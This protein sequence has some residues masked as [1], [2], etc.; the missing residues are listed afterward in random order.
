MGNLGRGGGV[1]DGAFAGFVG[2]Q[3]ALDAVHDDGA[4]SAGNGG[5]RRE[6]I[7]EDEPEDGRNL[8]QV[9]DQDDGRN[10]Q[11]ETGH[12]RDQPFRDFRDDL[13]AT[14]DNDGDEDRD[15]AAYDGAVPAQGSFQGQGDGVGLQGVV[16][17][18]E[19]DHQ[20]EREELGQFRHVQ[21]VGDVVRRAAVEG[22]A[23]LRDLVD[24]SQRAFDKARGAADDG[25]DPHPEDGA[26]AA[27]DDGDGHAGDVAD[28]DTGRRADAERLEGR[29]FLAFG[30]DTDAFQQAP[31]HFAETADLDEARPDCKVDAQAQQYDNQEL[32]PEESV[33][34]IDGSV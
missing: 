21:H 2:E 29:N 30:L 33:D 31:R 15:D 10:E 32:G 18:G 1:R 26:R 34:G 6:R 4:E 12:D 23:F 7:G 8:I 13:G 27:Q 22:A 9:E 5:L 28:T 14:A 17:Q 19:G 3:A 25:D 20:Q 11:I 24:L 16:D